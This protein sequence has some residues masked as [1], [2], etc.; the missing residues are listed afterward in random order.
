M[1]R[2]SITIERKR[3]GSFFFFPSV[4]FN[5][6]LRH[7]FLWST[8]GRSAAFVLWA[9]KT[10][11]L[12]ERT[13]VATMGEKNSKIKEESKMKKGEK[14]RICRTD[15]GQESEKCCRPQVFKVAHVY[16]SSSLAQIL[17]DA[18]HVIR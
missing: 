8:E 10:C 7:A 14:G 2:N 13:D 18:Q 5:F 1:L 4:F 16:L 6:F 9:E 15:D 17:T 3:D 12:V 11:K